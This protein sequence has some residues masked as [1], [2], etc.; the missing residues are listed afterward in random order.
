M[1]A[2]CRRAPCGR[3]RRRY[4]PARAPVHACRDCAR[5]PSTAAHQPRTPSGPPPGSATDRRHRVPAAVPDAVA[6]RNPSSPPR[7]FPRSAGSGSRLRP[8]P[9]RETVD[10]L[11]S[12]RRSRRRRCGRG[13]RDGGPDRGHW[14]RRSLSWRDAAASNG[15]W[16]N[17]DWFQAGGLSARV[18]EKIMR[19]FNS[20]ER[21]R[22]QN[23]IPF[24][25]IARE[26]VVRRLCSP[27]L[28]LRQVSF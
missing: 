27:S 22:M 18:G 13:R 6:G 10:G 21:D 19:S 4:R 9:H 14:A 3:P 7:L 2:N 20:L 16:R 25:R 26:A 23:R 17:L 5:P 24:F 1:S 8:A 12:S 15:A 28:Q 11:R